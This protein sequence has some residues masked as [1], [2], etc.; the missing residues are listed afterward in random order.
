M[1]RKML[2]ALGLAALVAVVVAAQARINPTDPQPTDLAATEYMPG[3][4]AC[5]VPGRPSEP[6]N[7]E[8]E[9]DHLLF[10][11]MINNSDRNKWE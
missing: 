1:M 4:H 10:D 11:Q 7:C 5:D 9:P 2:S 8:P 3:G 6:W